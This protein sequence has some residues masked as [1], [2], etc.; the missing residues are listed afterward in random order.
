[1]G[2]A[3]PGTRVLAAGGTHGPRGT[4]APVDPATAWVVSP[5]LLVAQA[6]S[7]ALRAAGSRVEV[8]VWES[9][10]DDAVAEHGSVATRHVV[11]IFDDPDGP[12][13]TEEVRRLLE[14]GDVRVAAV[15]PGP[16]LAWWGGLLEDGAVDVVT[17]TT[18]V[19]Q[20]V[21][22]V[23]RLLAGEPLMDPERRAAVRAAWAEVLDSRRRTVDLVETLSPQQ[24]RVLELLAAGHRAGEVAG[25]MG[26]TV[27]TVRSHVKALRAKLGARTQLEAVAMLRRAEEVRGPGVAEPDQV[28][29]TRPDALD[30]SADRTDRPGRTGRSLDG[31]LESDL[32][33]DLGEPGSDVGGLLPRP[34]RP[35]AGAEADESTRRH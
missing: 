21:E 20:L 16:A 31:G 4:S 24:R 6:V 1:M 22:V 29:G 33:E 26:V 13:V 2:G 11:A 30:R 12:S 9:L 19:S 15:V 3:T 7:A 5:H 27:G 32:E 35:A 14:V 25:L 17:R 28:P 8:H 23:E 18:S 34:R 10:V